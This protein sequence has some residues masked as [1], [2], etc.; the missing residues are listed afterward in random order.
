MRLCGTELSHQCEISKSQVSGQE[1][2]SFNTKMGKSWCSALPLNLSLPAEASASYSSPLLLLPAFL[3]L[4][5]NQNS[6]KPNLSFEGLAS[7]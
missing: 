4:I 2:F 7:P 3:T 5:Q 6:P 1:S